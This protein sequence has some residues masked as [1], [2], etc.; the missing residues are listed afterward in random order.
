MRTELQIVTPEGTARATEHRPD[1]A[2]PFPGALFLMD[3]PGLRETLREMA[4]RLA[5]QGYLV[6]LPDLFY[7]SPG[8][9]PFNPKTLWGDPAER[10]RVSALIG[11]ATVPAIAMRDVGLFLDALQARPGVKPGPVACFGYCMGGSLTLRA[12][13]AHPDRIAAAGVIHPG[14]P[15][16]DAPDSPHLGAPKIR[17]QVYVA[18]AD[19]D[20]SFTAEQRERLKAALDAAGVKNEV[21][22]YAGK[23]HG[24]AVP[25]LPPYDEKA[26]EKHWDRLLRLFHETL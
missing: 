16:T 21:E 3:G 25:D 6:L 12:A 24:F 10:A 15:A 26:A 7:R 23:G 20:P 22:F 4:D 17:A 11:A 13:A 19:N 1:G 2:G 14:R 5:A 9:P 18:A 8:Y